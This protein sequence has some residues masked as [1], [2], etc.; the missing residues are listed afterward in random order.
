MAKRPTPRWWL[1]RPAQNRKPATY[2]CPLCGAYLPALSAHMLIVP[3]GDSGR[4]RHAHSA[5]VMR[6]RS[7]GKL[8][9]REEW[10]RTLPES[11]RDQTT[12]SKLRARLRVRG[13]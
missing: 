9:T 1:I 11:A 8:P 10:Q 7:S 13:R 3:E 5:C 12:W 4:R 2:T 6:A